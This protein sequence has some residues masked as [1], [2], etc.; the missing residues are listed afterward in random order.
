MLQADTSQRKLTDDYSIKDDESM[1]RCA[2]KHIF[3]THAKRE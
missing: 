3:K 1:Q 2:N